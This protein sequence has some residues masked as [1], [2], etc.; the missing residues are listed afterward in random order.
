MSG[1]QMFRKLCVG[2]NFDLKK[3]EHDAIA[4]KLK[5]QED[6][7]D[8]ESV[9]KD[10]EI[11]A[12]QLRQKYEMHVIGEDLPDPICSFEQLFD[13]WQ[14]PSFLI[15]NLKK[16][17]FTSLTP[18]QMQ[19]IPLLLKKRELICCSS[20]GSGKT[21]SFLLPVITHLYRNPNQQMIDL[22]EKEGLDPTEGGDDESDDED[23]NPKD[24]KT[25][26]EEEEEGG[27]S[28]PA[29][30]SRKSSLFVRALI[31]APTGELGRQLYREALWFSNGSGLRVR[32]VNNVHKCRGGFVDILVTTPKRLVVLLKKRLIDASLA[33][34][35]VVD[36]CDRLFQHAFRAQMAY[37][38]QACL[39]SPS[40]SRALFSA[41]F[42]KNLQKW[43][44]LQLDSVCTLLVGQRL[45]VPRSVRQELRYVGDP[46][47]KYMAVQ[48][49]LQSGLRP[50]V[51][52][53]CQYKQTAAQLFGRMRHDK[54]NV[55]VLHSEVAEGKRITMINRLREGK[56]CF[57]ICTDLMGRGI[58]FK[59]VSC[60]LN[61]D[62]PNDA[63]SYIHRIGKH[64][65][66]HTFPLFST[67]SHVSL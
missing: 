48:Q 31:L 53:F 24:D 1:N 54:L 25:E 3:F 11:S 35:L 42:D 4:L 43:F 20:T 15:N 5:K 55:A 49:L 63:V 38:Y 46:N 62:Y 52:I 16:N 26:E 34:Y 56:L 19:A 41:T 60:V 51:L 23:Q 2:A 61:Y 8:D 33:D 57:L 6:K 27:E 64:L 36:E 44:E 7:D 67:H 65:F 17:K 59:G 18:V 14:V 50:P 47:G 58:D 39:T 30:K 28:K 10:S 29:K 40:M 22:I 32:L 66:H 13:D 9:G 12:D 37:V 21:L 45:V